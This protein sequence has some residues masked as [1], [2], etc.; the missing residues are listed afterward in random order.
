M[1]MQEM[2]PDLR[3]YAEGLH[4]S[5][6]PVD[7]HIDTDSNSPQDSLSV[8]FTVVTL[9]LVKVVIQLDGQGF[10]ALSLEPPHGIDNEHFKEMLSPRQQE[11]ASG[12]VYETIE[13]LLMAIS[14]QFEAFFGYEL[15]RRLDSISWDRAFPLA[16]SSTE[17]VGQLRA[18]IHL[19]KLVWF[20]DLEAED[21]AL[22]RVSIPVKAVD[23][24]RPIFLNEFVSTELDPTDDVADVF[25]DKPPEKTIH[26]IVQRPPQ[27]QL[28]FVPKDHIEQEL[29]VILNGVQ[30]HRTHPVDPKDVEAYKRG[31]GPFYKRTLPYHRTAKDI[32]LVMLGL[33]LDK[34]ARMTT[35][36]TL[37]SI[38][39]DDIGAVSGN[40]LVA[41][42]APSGSGKTTT[43]IDLA[44]KHFVI[45]C[46]CST[47]RATISPDFNDTN[48]ITL[49]TDVEKM[50]MAVVGEK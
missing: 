1:S 45:Y 47:P 33:D 12:H 40:R 25:K 22:S 38:V 4:Y 23:K 14:P 34:K 3:H 37:H 15:T 44:A 32:S 30:H 35:G 31:L 21:L 19:S 50:Y 28:K 8:S 36:E 27:A 11:A 26:I 18:A 41:M 5:T 10:R 29:A 48:F 9:E 39:E 49:A 43:V 2:I 46:F 20:K 42:V 16:I 24:L 7:T 6:F 17:T 13:A